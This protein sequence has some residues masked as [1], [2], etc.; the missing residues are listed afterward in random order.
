MRCECGRHTGMSLK[1]QRI[2]DG[3]RTQADRVFG[4]HAEHELGLL[5][6]IVDGVLQAVRVQGDDLR[7]FGRFAVSFLH[8][9]A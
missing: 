9:V 1:Q 2:G 6:Q 8:H 3:W 4:Q 7:P 5:L